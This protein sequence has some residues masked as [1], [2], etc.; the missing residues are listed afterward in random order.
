MI[1][2]RNLLATFAVAVLVYPAACVAQAIKPAPETPPQSVPED[3]RPGK[4]GSSQEPLGEKLDRTD[5]V[6]HP[7]QG[8]DP[9]IAVPPPASGSPMPV[10]PPPGTP[11]GKPGIEP[12]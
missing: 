5:G 10:I 9:G 8:L 4:S 7:P 2:L 1:R 11:G 12:K 6:I 3:T